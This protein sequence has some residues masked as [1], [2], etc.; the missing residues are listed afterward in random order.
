MV[1]E[2]LGGPRLPA[3]VL[4]HIVAQ[5]DGIP[6]FVEEV[7]KAVVETGPYTAVP[8]QNAATGPLPALAIPA[9]LHEALLARLDRLG[10][11]KGVAQLG[12]VLGRQFPY[13]QLRAVAPLED[14]TLQ[15]DLATLVAAELLYQR[16][17]PPRATYM[18]KH[19]L[20]QEAAYESVLQRVRRH[21][22]QRI[23]Q[24][25]EAQFPET[26]ATAP[27]LLAHHARRGELWDKAVTYFRRAGEQVVA[28]SAYR[29]AVAAFEQALK[30][31]HHLPESCDTRTQALDIRL[32]LHSALY[33]LG[34]LGRVFVNL[35]D[36][37]ALAETL[38]DPH[39]LG[40][41]ATYLLAP[42][43]AACEPDHALVFGQR[44]LAIAEDLGEV[45][46]TVTAQT[47]LGS[48]YRSLGD[49]RRSVDFYQKNVAYLH[50]ALLYEHLG[51]PGPASALCR[52]HLVASLAECGAFAE[53]RARAA[54]GVQI[55]E[56]V[57]HPY[58][59]V[60]AYWA[61][62]FLALRQGDLPQAIP[63]LEQALALAH[64]QLDTFFVLE[65][66]EL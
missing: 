60:V 46:I 25:L 23:V 61:V 28:R 1:E 16:G 2:M 57:D 37:Q 65:G 54:E 53:G 11:A 34:E 29:E 59:R 10:S 38:S 8:E 36:A 64:C 19:A 33:L 40:W 18:F 50:G 43:V 31:V 52:S 41:V 9:T 62:G 27:E 66:L 4:A 56:A 45:G 35:Q 32:A 22:H 55:A 42:F 21:T 20:I 14:A 6:L 30:A 17:Q 44:A 63:V 13:A 15:R 51:L 24:V 5:T 49:Y 12:A 48:L 3:A 39:R 58:S 26:A 7:T 47:W